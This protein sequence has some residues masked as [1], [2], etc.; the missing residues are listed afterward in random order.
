MHND[1][2]SGGGEEVYMKRQMDVKAIGNLSGYE[3]M[4]VLDNYS[5]KFQ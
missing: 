3:R 2:C 4:S 1:E 5:I